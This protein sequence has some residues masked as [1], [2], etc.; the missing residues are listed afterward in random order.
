M[1]AM[2]DVSVDYLT[3]SCRT[4]VHVYIRE[5]LCFILENKLSCQGNKE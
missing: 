5:S 1:S 3:F 2:D 4:Y